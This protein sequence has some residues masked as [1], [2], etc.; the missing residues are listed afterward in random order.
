MPKKRRV[1]TVERELRAMVIGSYAAMAG[2][3]SFS[4]I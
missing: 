1:S 4:L 2:A 3:V